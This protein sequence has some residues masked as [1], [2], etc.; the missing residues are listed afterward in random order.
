MLKQAFDE[1]KSARDKFGDD[2]VFV[3]QDIKP[4]FPAKVYSWEPWDKIKYDG[5]RSKM[6]EVLFDDISC[7]F[8]VKAKITS[9]AS[10]TLDEYLSLI[11]DVIVSTWNREFR[12]KISRTDFVV[13]SNDFDTFHIFLPHF[14]FV[15][16]SAVYSFMRKVEMACFKSKTMH[17]YLQQIKSST[18]F[19]LSIYRNHYSLPMLHHTRFGKRLLPIQGEDR[20]QFLAHNR[21]LLPF[22]TKVTDFSEEVKGDPTKAAVLDATNSCKLLTV[23]P[24]HLFG[25]ETLVEFLLQCKRAALR[26]EDV[27]H[28][29][30]FRF[31]IRE[32]RPFNLFYESLNMDQ[33]TYCSA[34]LVDFLKAFVRTDILRE[35]TEVPDLFQKALE[36]KSNEYCLPDGRA[37]K[38]DVKNLDMFPHQAFLSVS[39]MGSGKTY[40]QLQLVSDMIRADPNVSVIVLSCRQLMAKDIER[41][42][43]EVIPDIVNYLTL[44]QEHKNRTKFV[45]ALNLSKRL[46]V[47]LESL[48][49]I[50]TTPE[51]L[52]FRHKKL[53]F[54]I[55][56]AETV[57]AQF[58]SQTMATHYRTTWTTFRALVEHASVVL[59]GE[60]VPSLRTYEMCQ[61]LCPSLIIERNL[62][63]RV[64][65]TPV[66]K[67]IQYDNYSMLFRMLVLQVQSGKRCGVFC[68]TRE[69]AKSIHQLLEKYAISSQVY[70]SEDRTSHHEFENLHENWDKYQVVIWTSVVTVGISYDL[71]T[72][73]FMTAF[74]SSKGPFMRDSIQAVHRIRKLNDEALHWAA[75]G[76]LV[77]KE[78]EEKQE[79]EEEDEVSFFETNEVML[80]LLDERNSK[81]DRQ[82]SDMVDAADP[83]IK[84]LVFYHYYESK[85][86]S[87]NAQAG[88]LFEYFLKKYVGYET[89]VGSSSLNY[90][91]PAE[92]TS[93]AW[94]E[95]GFRH[96]E[97]DVSFTTFSRDLFTEDWQNHLFITVGPTTQSVFESNADMFE[98]NRE[99]IEDRKIIKNVVSML[100]WLHAHKFIDTDDSE[101]MEAAWE[102]FCGTR[103][104]TR[105]PLVLAQDLNHDLAL[106][107]AGVEQKIFTQNDRSLAS[108]SIVNELVVRWELQ[109]ICN[110]EHSYLEGPVIT[111]VELNAQSARI[112][113][114]YT[115]LFGPS[116][117]QKYNPKNLRVMIRKMVAKL[118]IGAEFDVQKSQKGQTV[119]YLCKWKPIEMAAKGAVLASGQVALSPVKDETLPVSQKR[120]ELSDKD[121]GVKKPRTKK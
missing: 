38:I 8:F 12:E 91:A 102:D 86:Q 37:K 35:I 6:Y 72:F 103:S 121:R 93:Y 3:A 18:V 97:I 59:F 94:T 76:P 16:I 117:V 52:N 79:E 82:F 88:A 57:F 58:I 51:M 71:L 32:A 1:Y 107:N 65:G 22:P 78:E 54:I 47:Q 36:F 33:T 68:S 10:F 31:G 14:Q 95:I 70:H 42:Y 113:S 80:K 48:H 111:D 26:N 41:R 90:E 39:P 104:W 87:T 83:M 101:F 5:E 92:K 7:R 84:R 40:Q 75:K 115:Q 108:D 56:E 11:F 55:D 50:D 109:R 89:E 118:D 85:L 105:F 17:T 25:Q 23:V 74:I 99:S 66:R 53:L 43:K 28:L 61:H 2:I 77:A 63:P 112:H 49:N 4:P 21:T 96:D 67:A 30:Q 116:R 15:G 114:L 69:M 60:A 98:T 100:T 27:F 9:F 110:V 106:K 19:D 81:L 64:T 44:R 20:E 34:G 46:I 119:S 73:D 45:R 29:L 13:A 120:K 24:I 62:A